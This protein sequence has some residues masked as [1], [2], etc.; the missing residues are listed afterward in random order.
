[1]LLRKLQGRKNTFI[2]LNFIEKNLYMLPQIVQIP[3][4]QGLTTYAL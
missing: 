3:V 2:V 4:A 1:M